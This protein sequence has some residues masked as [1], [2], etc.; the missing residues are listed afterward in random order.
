MEIGSYLSGGVDSTLVAGL[1]DKPHTWTVG[2]KQLNE[3]SWGRIAAEAF[4]SSH[5]E[6]LINNNYIVS[7]ISE[8]QSSKL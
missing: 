5:H 2:F 7:I 4:G 8:E 1:A 3:F 6:I